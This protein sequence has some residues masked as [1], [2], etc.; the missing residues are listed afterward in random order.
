MHWARKQYINESQLPKYICLQYDMIMNIDHT[1]SGAPCLPGVVWTQG[2]DSSEAG[3]PG[4]YASVKTPRE[5]W[6]N[7]HKANEPCVHVTQERCQE[8]NMRPWSLDPKSTL[9]SLRLSGDWNLQKGTKE[10][11]ETVHPALTTKRNNPHRNYTVHC[12]QPGIRTCCLQ[13]LSVLKDIIN[14]FHI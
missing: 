3:H 8:P 13:T 4:N 10:Q 7:L 9:T 6:R 1:C 12:F 5:G 2:T 14:F 11:A